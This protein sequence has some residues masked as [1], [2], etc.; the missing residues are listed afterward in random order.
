MPSPRLFPTR[1][2]TVARGSIPSV[3]RLTIRL[4]SVYLLFALVGRFV[5][6]MRAVRCP[7]RPDCWCKK[8]VLSIFRW[9]FPVGH[10]LKADCSA[11]D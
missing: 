8:P 4:L 11:I 6:G 1:S 2:A 10:R 9:V 5:E 7:C 3:R